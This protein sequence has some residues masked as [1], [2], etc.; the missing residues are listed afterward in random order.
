M[1]FEIGN[2]T[3]VI[4]LTGGNSVLQH[5]QGVFL[6]KVE[7]DIYNERSVYHFQTQYLE[8]SLCTSGKLEDINSIHLFNETL[9]KALCTWLVKI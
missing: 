6:E 9:Q 5:F 2:E 4:Y 3:D 1:S 8:Y 7:C